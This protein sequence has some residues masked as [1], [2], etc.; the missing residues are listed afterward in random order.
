MAES[1]DGRPPQQVYDV[2][3]LFAPLLQRELAAAHAALA[4]VSG[5]GLTIVPGTVELRKPAPVGG[6]N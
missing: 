2:F 1:S 6:K 3:A 5:A 4:A